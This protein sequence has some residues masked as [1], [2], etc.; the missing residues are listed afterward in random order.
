MR[1]E[2]RFFTRAALDECNEAEP[3]SDSFELCRK[4]WDEIL[5]AY[6][7][8]K[9]I[10]QRFW[11]ES[12]QSFLKRR[13][14]FHDESVYRIDVNTEEC[15]VK[16]MTSLGE[17]HLSGVRWFSGDFELDDGGDAWLYD[18]FVTPT[19]ETDCAEGFVEFNILLQFGE[20]S[21]TALDIEFISQ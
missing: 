4:A 11:S 15:R 18:E 17:L 9:R 1:D 2:M 7:E 8:H 16:M 5:E 3:D 13:I 12:V 6:R 10:H 19:R 21:I 14:S 20:I